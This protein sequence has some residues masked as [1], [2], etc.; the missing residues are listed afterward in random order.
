MNEEQPRWLF[1]FNSVSITN[2]RAYVTLLLVIGTAV[3]YWITNIPPVESWL[4]FLASMSGIDAAQFFSKRKTF[5]ASTNGVPVVDESQESTA[6]TDLQ[7]LPQQ[8]G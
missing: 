6:S 2:L 4:V 3:R 5:Q 1:L 7:E 8:K